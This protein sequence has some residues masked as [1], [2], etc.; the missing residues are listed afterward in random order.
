MGEAAAVVIVADKVVVDE[1]FNL[2][3]RWQSKR[4][5]GPNRRGHRV[6]DS[7]HRCFPSLQRDGHGTGPELWEARL[8]GISSEIS[9]WVWVKCLRVLTSFPDFPARFLDLRLKVSEARACLQEYFMAAKIG[10]Q[11]AAQKRLHLG[12]C[13]FADI[14]RS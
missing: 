12:A 1:A 8:P 9:A 5:R 2:N 7:W 10:E 6:H 13:P 4:P 3:N 14:S 11:G